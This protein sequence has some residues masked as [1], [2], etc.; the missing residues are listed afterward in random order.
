MPTAL[1]AF[2]RYTIIWVC[3]AEFTETIFALDLITVHLDYR[4]VWNIEHTDHGVR[5]GQSVGKLI[6]TQR[7]Q[8]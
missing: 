1:G 7:T 5:L 4:R 6:E 2:R 3:R 8:S